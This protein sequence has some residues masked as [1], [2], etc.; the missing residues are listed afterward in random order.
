MLLLPRLDFLPVEVWH[1]MAFFLLW[2]ILDNLRPKAF[3]E[4][5]KC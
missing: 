3:I 4:K 5:P 1:A 2:N